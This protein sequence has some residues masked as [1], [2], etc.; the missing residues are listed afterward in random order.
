MPAPTAWPLVLAL[1]IA[2]MA[3]GL[4]TNLGFLFV[5]ALVM[6]IGLGGWIGQLLPGQGHMHEPLVE[7]SRRPAATAQAPG[8]VDALRPGAAGYRFRL[9]EHV[10]PISS[11]VK[12]G[13][14]GGLLMPIPALA[15]GVIEHGSLWFPINLLVGMVVPGMA[16]AD[17]DTLKAF[18]LGALIVGIVIHAAFS[19][20]FGLM[21]G[22]IL[23]M[24]PTFRG[25]PFFFG[26]VLMP[27]FW[28]GVCY[29]MMGIVNPA[30]EEH[31]SWPWFIAS[32]FV[33]G[34]AMSYMVFRSEKIA[35]AQPVPR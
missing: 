9:P 8:T 26:G 2:L 34:V 32:Q 29:G 33:F 5:G 7:P 1:G 23:P 16:D 35:V 19:V 4:A 31:V 25:S 24:L 20:T 28:T 12:G 6:L 27:I 13:I 21:Y 15:Y 11:G 22:V 30:L 10:H 18:H 14:V 3:M 17:L